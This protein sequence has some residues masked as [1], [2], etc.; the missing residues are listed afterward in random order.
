MRRFKLSFPI[1]FLIANT[2]FP[3]TLIFLRYYA[4][5]SSHGSYVSYCLERLIACYALLLIAPIYG[6]LSDSFSQFPGIHLWW[7]GPISLLC[8]SWYAI[9]F[10]FVGT[11][12][13]RLW[14]LIPAFTRS[15]T[16]SCGAGKAVGNQSGVRLP[17]PPRPSGVGKR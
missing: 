17:A 10:V 6:F 1:W 16:A 14:R 4:A 8:A 2:V 13:S 11:V 5:V 3:L 15:C 9:V 12:F 7:L